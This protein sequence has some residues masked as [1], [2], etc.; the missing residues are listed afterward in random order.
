MRLRGTITVSCLIWILSPGGALGEQ[1]NSN[2]L[3]DGSYIRFNYDG[4]APE[5]SIRIP[6]VDKVFRIQGGDD[7]RFPLGNYYDVKVPLSY[8]LTKRLSFQMVPSIERI[9]SLQSPFDITTQGPG[10]P[11]NSLFGLGA[12]HRTQQFLF[13]VGLRFGF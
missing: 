13:V 12:S 6:Y 9:Y 5:V 3:L 10:M 1:A 11:L 7:N 4:V 8:Q 2:L